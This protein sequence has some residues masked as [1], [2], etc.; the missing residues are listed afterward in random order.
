[1]LNHVGAAGAHKLR[2]YACA[3]CRRVWHLLCDRRSCRAV[4]AAERFACGRATAEDLTAAALAASAA[5]EQ[6]G[7]SRDPHY[8][9]SRAALAT[10]EPSGWI[11]AWDA[12]W[13]ARLAARDASREVRRWIGSKPYA[14]AWERERADQAALLRELYASPFRPVHIDPRWMDLNDGAVHTLARVIH[15]QQRYDDLPFLGDALEEAGCTDARLLDHCRQAGPHLR[16]CW[17][18]DDLLAACLV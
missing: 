14:V 4:E 17:L 3:C 11:A 6:L 1:M 13:E 7:G 15:E 9:A 5:T 10:T 18:L 8:H 2:L 12:G 16:G